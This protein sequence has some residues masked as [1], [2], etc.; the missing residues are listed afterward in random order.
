MLVGV[1]EN[2]EEVQELLWYERATLG[3]GGIAESSRSLVSVYEKSWRAA[4][5]RATQVRT[6]PD[7]VGPGQ[8]A[9]STESSRIFLW[10]KQQ[11]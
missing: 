1:R 3:A 2:W 5:G 9:V 4:L 8:E 11:N 10:F 6:L 7:D